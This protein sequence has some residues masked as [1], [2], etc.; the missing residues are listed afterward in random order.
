MKMKLCG[1]SRMD[2]IEAVNRIK[3]D[4]IGFVFAKKS[5]RYV[6]PEQAAA[7]K[8]H[9]DPAVRAVGVFVDEE[10]QAVAALLN[11]NIIDMAQL[12]GHESDAYIDE[13]RL[14]TDKPIMK[15]F[16][17]KSATDIENANCSHAD[18]V[19]LDSVAGGS[20]TAFDWQLLKNICRDFFLAGG[21]NADNVR[22]AR[23]YSPYAVDVSSAIETDGYKDSKKMAAFA[24]AVRKDDDI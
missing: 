10:V 17:V 9:L 6:S 16:A 5:R 11:K 12:H 1:L 4:Y 22:M 23:Q 20:G 24:A 7:L 15:A 8:K 18:Y 3:P 13:L 14:Y 2:D 21:V 19:L